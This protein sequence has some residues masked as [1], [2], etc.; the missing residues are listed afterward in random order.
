L[1]SNLPFNLPTDDS[2]RANASAPADRLSLPREGG[3]SR[4]DR[5]DPIARSASAVYEAHGE[6]VWKSLY[7][8]GVAE[9]D[10]EDMV[11]EVFVVVHRRLDSYDGTAKLT[12]WLFGISLRVAS[13][14][15]RTAHRRKEI[16]VDPLL[17]DER[18]DA[19]ATPEEALSLRQA[20]G[21]LSSVLDRMDLEKRAVFVMFEIEQMPCADIAA[22]LDVPV[23]TVY[24]RL[25]A[26]RKV[27]E[28]E[29]SRLS[30][31]DDPSKIPGAND[32]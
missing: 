21:R 25:H 2:D 11:Q 23:G 9:C 26:A 29:L 7:R 4:S 10:L 13:T 16:A 1:G 15:R 27:F 30:R 31:L 22:L 12:T 14:Y 20:R 24:S 18:I 5:P 17:A 8:L 32:E 6:F 3:E 19:S 28:A